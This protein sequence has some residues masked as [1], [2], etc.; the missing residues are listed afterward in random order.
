[1]HF[2]GF[3]IVV[4]LI[5]AICGCGSSS[6]EKETPT[7]TNSAPQAKIIAEYDTQSENGVLSL[8]ARQ[9][10]DPDNDTLVY[11]WEIISPSGDVLALENVSVDLLS[12]RAWQSGE[13]KVSLTVTDSKGL[14]NKSESRVE[15]KPLKETEAQIVGLKTVKQGQYLEYSA[16][17][18]N[19]DLESASYQWQ[20]ISLPQD[21]I[22]ELTTV[23][24]V[25]TSFTADKAGNYRLKLKVTDSHNLSVETELAIEAIAV[26]ENLPPVAIIT[27]DKERLLPNESVTLSAATSFDVENDV[28]S[29]AWEVVSHPT[30]AVYSLGSAN[31][32]QISFS[33]NEFGE[34]TIRLTVSDMH[35]SSSVDELVTVVSDNRPPRAQIEMSGTGHVKPGD[36]VTLHAKGTDPEGDAVTYKWRLFIKPRDSQA[37][38]NDNTAETVSYTTDKE[39]DYVVAL[40]VSDAYSSSFPAGK[41][42]SAYD[43]FAPEVVTLDYSSTMTVDTSQNLA[44]S[45]SDVE[46]GVL[47][48]D[49]IMQSQPEN[50]VVNLVKKTES[51]MTFSTDTVGEYQIGVTV[52]D[53]GGKSSRMALFVIQVM[54]N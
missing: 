14:S 1:M 13:Y 7:N 40:L 15:I 8:D 43:N 54:Q 31:A 42:V 53:S 2:K 5:L 30:G 52:T 17:L 32:E 47:A 48:Y 28:L 26:T 51:E 21:S 38:L 39:G 49:W 9:S 19:I 22:A 45:A 35:G 25:N 24:G 18:S 27:R 3:S 10:S 29:F 34:F 11:L 4:T 50:A 46:P 6:G 36:T 33:S 37:V 44:V 12:F 23:E 41:K 16:T 20:I